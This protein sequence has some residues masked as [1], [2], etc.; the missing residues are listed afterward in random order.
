MEVIKIPPTNLIKYKGNLYENQQQRN[1][2]QKNAI[3]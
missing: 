2:Y 3:N 1:I